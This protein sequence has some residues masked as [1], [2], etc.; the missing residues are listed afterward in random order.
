MRHHMI[1][2]TIHGRYRRVNRYAGYRS[3]Q[4]KP[5]PRRTSAR[6]KGGCEGHQG[7]PRRGDPY[8]LTEMNR[9]PVG[10]RGVFGESSGKVA[11]S[12]GVRMQQGG[13][14]KENSASN[15]GNGADASE[16]PGG[17]QV[18]YW[19]LGQDSNLQPSG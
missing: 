7:H 15:G 17:I 2:H 3:G 10:T 11:R 6:L 12:A 1:G 4:A 16:R 9:D 13:H 14:E 5:G 18:L 19:L 8:E